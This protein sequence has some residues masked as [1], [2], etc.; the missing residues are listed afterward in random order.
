[1]LAVLGLDDRI[2]DRV[3]VAARGLVP[4]ATA[5]TDLPS[6]HLDHRDTDTRPGH[7]QVGLVLG[8]T[9]DHRHRVQ[10]HRLVGKLI[11]QDL[12]DAP[13][14]RPAP[15]ELGFARIAAWGHDHC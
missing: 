1:M 8:S 5:A 4:P 10:Q 11:A 12:P 14:G 9:L 6:L 13:L 7:N 2:L 3:R 15:A